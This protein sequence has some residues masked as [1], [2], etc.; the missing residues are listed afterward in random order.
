MYE[1]KH[2]R[3]WLS[4]VPCSSF[5]PLVGLP[6]FPP[7]TFCPQSGYGPERTESAKVFPLLDVERGYCVHYVLCYFMDLCGLN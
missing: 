1:V 5:F 2:Y 3:Q 7:V 6:L 4:V